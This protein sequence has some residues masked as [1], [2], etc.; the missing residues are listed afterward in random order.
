MTPVMTFANPPVY[1][2]FRPFFFFLS[3]Q[4]PG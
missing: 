3:F 4:P 2:N 1:S